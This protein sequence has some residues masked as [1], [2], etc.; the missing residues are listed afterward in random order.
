MPSAPAS[1]PILPPAA[2]F[3]RLVETGRSLQAIIGGRVTLSGPYPILEDSNP[4]FQAL[5]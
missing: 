2:A 3:V 1:T 4:W 5:C